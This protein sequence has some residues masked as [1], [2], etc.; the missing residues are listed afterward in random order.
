[1]LNDK[2]YD[3]LK[4]VVQIVLPAIGTLYFAL[5]G[6]WGF[7]AADKVIGTISAITAFLGVV[8]GISS[9]KYKAPTDGTLTI[10]TSDEAKDSY[11]FYVE[12]PLDELPAKKTITMKVET[13]DN[14]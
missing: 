9:A 2:V 7:P 11:K 13:K 8:L 1:M 6:I 10:D 3:I 14:V 5:S 12:T 4:R